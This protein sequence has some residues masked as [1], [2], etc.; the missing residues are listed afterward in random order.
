[1]HTDPHMVT[2]ESAQFRGHHVGI[3]P[4]GCPKP[5]SQTGRGPHASFT[6]ELIQAAQQGVG[7]L[8]IHFG[9]LHLHIVC[10]RGWKPWLQCSG[11]GVLPWK[12]PLGVIRRLVWLA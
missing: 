11:Y 1:M 10:E 6:V 9:G 12:V 3:R 7:G 4:D 8:D 5:P 2:L